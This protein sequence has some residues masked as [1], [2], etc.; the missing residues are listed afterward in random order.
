[1]KP[2]LA[3]V[4]FAVGCAHATDSQIIAV[5]DKPST[6]MTVDTVDTARLR[7]DQTSAAEAAHALVELMAAQM[8]TVGMVRAPVGD[9]EIA[10]ELPAPGWVLRARLAMRPELFCVL[11]LE[12]LAT[13]P[14]LHAVTAAPWSVHDAFER[15]HRGLL[16][17]RP[18]REPPMPPP[19][20]ARLRREATV[21]AQ[22]NRDPSLTQHEYKRT[23]RPISEQ[24]ERPYYTP[25]M[26][27]AN[28]MEQQ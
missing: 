16:S 21:A 4:L 2:S 7:S 9:E 24:P 20:F 17:L 1:M 26:D 10:V 18:P 22:A 11:T 14:T 23:P 19:R 27:A 25:T 13:Q 8:A 28:V 3:V 12:P 6:L 15:V 5:A